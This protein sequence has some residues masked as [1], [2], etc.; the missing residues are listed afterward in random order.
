[1]AAPIN[2][3]PICRIVFA[4]T[5]IAIGVIG[6]ASGDFGPIWQPVPHSFPDRELLIYLCALVSMISGAGLISARSTPAAALL[7]LIYLCIW[8][9]L[10]KLPFII[11]EPLVEGSY[12]SFGESA[13]LIAAVWLL[14]A[15]AG[16][17]AK[18]GFTARLAA[19]M[20][21]KVAYALY[22]LSLVAFGFSHFAYLNLTAPLVPSWLPAPIFWAYLTGCTYVAAGFAILS[23]LARRL[24]ALIAALQIALIT[25]L[26]WGAM[27]IS[28]AMSPSRWQEAIV[29]W[30]LTSA[31]LIVAASLGNQA[32]S[33]RFATF[34][35]RGRE[36]EAV[37]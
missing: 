37:N 22:G 10:F 5:M 28:S 27:L 25:F 3:L 23:G 35:T 16:E 9:A 21:L 18:T 12:Q 34:S 33:G 13:V 36:I 1:M 19:P 4:A 20:G 26:V 6:V 30:A 15:C 7:L 32:W 8:T 14:F 2:L 24:G 29:S 31:A 17:T 11:R